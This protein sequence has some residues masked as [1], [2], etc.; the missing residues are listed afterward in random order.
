MTG[1]ARAATEPGS[2]GLRL[3]RHLPAPPDEVFR[4]LS[5][6]E[7]MRQWMSPVGSAE[8][9]ADLRVGGRFRVVMSGDGMSLEHTGAYLEVDPP[10]SLEFTWSSPYTGPEPSVVRVVL[11]PRDGGTHMVL[12]HD[13]LPLAAVESHAGGWGAMLGRLEAAITAGGE[14]RGS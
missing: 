2:T 4:Y 3:E 11:T 10:R 14:A 1:D 6:P 7:L 13:R 12:T 8:A 9:E 5:E